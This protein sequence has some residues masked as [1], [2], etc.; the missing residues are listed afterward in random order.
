MNNQT[1]NYI[2]GSLVGLIDRDQREEIAKEI[3]EQT[4]ELKSIYDIERI[5]KGILISKVEESMENQ[6]VRVSKE[7]SRFLIDKQKDL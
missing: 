7:L 3:E 6:A 4:K 5:C 2:F 1:Y